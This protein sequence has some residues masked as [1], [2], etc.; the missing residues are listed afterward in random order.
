MSMNK[1]SFLYLSLVVLSVLAVVGCASRAVPAVSEQT[2]MVEEAP[3][4]ERD[5]DA[6]Q[7]ARQSNVIGLPQERMIIRT[8]DMELIVQDTAASLESVHALVAEFDGYIASSQ[9]WHEE[10]VLAAQLTIRVPE[11]DLETV[12]ERLHTLGRVESENQS[13]EDVTDQ[14]VNLEARLKNLEL[15]EQ[16]LQELLETRQETGKTEDILEVY[17]ELVNIRG[18]IE[19]IKGQMQNLENLTA[20]AT[21]SLTLTPDALTQPVV[22]GRWQPQGTARDATRALIK[23][24]QFLINASIWIVIL[25]IPM[26]IILATPFVVLALIVR[27]WRRRKRRRTAG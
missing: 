3:S 20:L 21:I 24:V 12:I 22:I 19:Q 13:G 8:V 2:V 4:G 6:Y 17:R 27:A 10:D 9:S 7:Y 1:K 23:A 5:A 11:A 26:L 14:Y 16:E 15:A 18:Q 25:G